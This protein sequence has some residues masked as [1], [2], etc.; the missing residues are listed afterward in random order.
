MRPILVTT[1]RSGSTIILR[2]LGSLATQ[3]FSCKGILHEPFTITE[4]F[5]S[6]YKKINNIITIV[7]HERLGYK[8]FDSKREE[9]LKVISL[10]KDDYD[11]VFKLFPIDMEIEIEDMIKCYYAPI[12]LERKDKIEQLLSWVRLFTTNVAH[13]LKT[14]AQQ[15]TE[16]RYDAFHAN[17]L[18]RHLSAYRAYNDSC[19]NYKLIFYEDFLQQG[20]DESA[21]IHLLGLP[22]IK[23]TQLDILTKPTPYCT[24]LEDIITNKDEWLRDKPMLIRR[25]SDLGF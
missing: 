5:K 22:I 15:V 6:D 8:W 18:I 17:E 4:L 23:Y 25:I 14:D 16:L 20:A 13:F 21:L 3:H 2:L 24:S 9:K 11:Y 10:L 19:T 12:L 7:N 1:P